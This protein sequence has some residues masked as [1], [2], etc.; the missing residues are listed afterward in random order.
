ME[1]Y[2]FAGGLVGRMVGEGGEHYEALSAKSIG[3]VKTHR[4]TAE[5]FFDQY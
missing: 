4:G 3:A 2:C 1:I 5:H